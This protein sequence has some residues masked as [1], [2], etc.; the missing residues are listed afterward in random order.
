MAGETG[1]HVQRA[2]VGPLDV[3]E[4]EHDGAG[5]SQRGEHPS[6]LL[7]HDAGADILG[8]AIGSV[9]Q[10]REPEQVRVTGIG[11]RATGL[12]GVGDERRERL[13]ERAEDPARAVPLAEPAEHEHAE[14]VRGAADLAEET[15]LA[16]A[17]SG[18]D[19]DDG[20]AS[21]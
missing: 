12:V 5:A 20:R 2:L 17:R 8:L 13:G 11:W 6:Y 3:V 7:G 21:P 16:E 4:D 10:P 15:G 18:D 14:G 1:Q 9:G 19:V